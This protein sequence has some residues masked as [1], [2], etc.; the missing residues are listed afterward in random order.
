MIFAEKVKHERDKLYLSQEQLGERIGV[1][2]RSV[3]A[4]ENEKI[5]PRD[6][7]MRKLA[8]TLG[9]SM[10]YLKN[11]SIDDPNHGKTREAQIDNVRQRFG[12]RA[13]NEAVQLLDQNAAFFAGGEF[14]QED[15]DAFFEAVMS[16]YLACK[17]TARAKFGR[18]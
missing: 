1:T 12:A 6:R 8:Q 5:I 2:R 4:Y 3:N 11:D 18:V 7:V 9:V 13:A 14:P 10:E 16:A 17:E 15:K